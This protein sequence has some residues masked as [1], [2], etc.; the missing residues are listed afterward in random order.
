MYPPMVDF[1]YGLERQKTLRGEPVREH[2]VLRYGRGPDVW[3]ALNQAAIRF[4]AKLENWG[5]LPCALMEPACDMQS[6]R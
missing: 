1:N 2:P 4:R 5:Q 3:H 6:T